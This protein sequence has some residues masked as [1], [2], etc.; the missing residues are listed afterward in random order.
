MND[1]Q[2]SSWFPGVFSCDCWFH[3]NSLSD[4]SKFCITMLLPVSV[5]FK[6]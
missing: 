2:F 1:G 6:S 3:L 4:F 5:E